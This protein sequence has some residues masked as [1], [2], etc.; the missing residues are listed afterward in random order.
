[1][2]SFSAT[3]AMQSQP[4][5]VPLIDVLLVLLIVFMVSM[6]LMTKT[7]DWTLSGADPG[8]TAKP[9]TQWSLTVD[10]S[11]VIHFQGQAVGPTELMRLVDSAFQAEPNGLIVLDIDPDA[12]YQAALSTQALLRNAHIERVRIKGL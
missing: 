10:G 8:G 4:N 11:D 6:P 7:L 5:I 3:R 2:N 1:M 12:S 9:A